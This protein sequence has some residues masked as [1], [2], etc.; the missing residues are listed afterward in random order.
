MEVPLNH[1]NVWHSYDKLT[2]RD[3]VMHMKAVNAADLNY[4][5]IID[6]DGELMDGRHRLMKAM[7]NGVD[8]VKVVKFEENPSPCQVKD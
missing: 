7:L 8:T 1:L 2:L 5:I 3:M 6:E 4:P